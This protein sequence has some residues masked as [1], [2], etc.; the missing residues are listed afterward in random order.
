MASIIFKSDIFGSDNE[1]FISKWG[2]YYSEFKND[3][4][5]IS[6]QYYFIF[7]LRRLCF[8]LSQIYLNSYPLIQG[9]LNI[10][11][12][13]IQ[14]GFLLYFRPFKEKT[15]LL[16]NLVGEI[17]ITITMGLVYSLMFIKSLSIFA[18]TE[19]AIIFIVLLSVGFEIIISIYIAVKAFISLI[20]IIM[21]QRELRSLQKV[22]VTVETKYTIENDIK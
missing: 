22:R 15:V 3:K 9:G 12:S 11:G 19:A 8:C 14:T 1:T 13:I 18:K 6:S 4:G 17:C 20:K 5:F 7:F 21:K 2:C 16:S 10:L